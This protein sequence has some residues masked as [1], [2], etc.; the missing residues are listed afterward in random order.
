MAQLLSRIRS[1]VTIV[2][3]STV[4][5]LAGLAA[6]AVTHAQNT[7]TQQQNFQFHYQ[8]GDP[9]FVGFDWPWQS[10]NLFQV[11]QDSGVDVDALLQA[12]GHGIDWLLAN[13]G[14]TT[15]FLLERSQVSVEFL[16]NASGQTTDWLIGELG[17]D[18]DW[19]L[20]QAGHGS[21]WLL[22]R[23]GAA[24]DQ[25]LAWA[26]KDADWLL[27]QLDKDVDWLLDRTG[28]NVSWMLNRAGKGSSWVASQVKGIL[29][30][31]L[32]GMA[33][34][35]CNATVDAVKNSVSKLLGLLDRTGA[36]WLNRA[37]KSVDWLLGAAG[38]NTDWML[39]QAGRN[40][41]WLWEKLGKDADW[42]LA[43]TGKTKSW[44]LT[45][46]GHD[47]DWLLQRAGQGNSWLFQRLGKN[48]SWLLQQTNHD[49]DWVL[50][51]I[52]W[53]MSEA[54]LRFTLQL[55]L[56]VVTSTGLELSYPGAAQIQYVP[57]T[58]QTPEYERRIAVLTGQIKAAEGLGAT[59]A[60]VALTYTDPT[61]VSFSQT[62]DAGVFNQDMAITIDT[63]RR[64]FRDT[65]HADG[66]L[67]TLCIPLK[68]IISALLV[69]VPPAAATTL[70]LVPDVMMQ[71]NG[72]VGIRLRQEQ[73]TPAMGQIDT[74]R[75]SQ[76]QPAYEFQMNYSGNR[77]ADARLNGGSWGFAWG[78][79]CGPGVGISMGYD[80]PGGQTL[81][82]AGP[83]A[84]SDQQSVRFVLPPPSD[85]QRQ[86]RPPTRPLPGRTPLPI[87]PSPQPQPVQPVQPITPQPST[88]PVQ[89]TED[90]P[91]PMQLQPKQES[92]D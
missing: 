88:Q 56:Q 82:E 75:F 62:G 13:T 12:S 18:A 90:Q 73:V 76:P 6:P 67:L 91:P 11:L 3:V 45:L 15:E 87:Q 80:I 14:T 17:K 42:L 81:A 58:P 74:I 9:S 92:D 27:G 64:I 33:K 44:L 30:S 70:L 55:Q 57:G 86:P 40:R 38:R 83:G 89:P 84:M 25:L 61:G 23:S 10:P 20:D 2:A 7:Q 32:S 1:V 52:G 65:R 24:T 85:W 66:W 46:V 71:I 49:A 37:D 59:N 78:L 72:D 54:E 51:Q 5:V 50:E 43:H 48:A 39:S 19:I 63:S 8:I 21:D 26:D 47:A 31:H 16:L 41:T 60:G 79:M 77:Y 34:S 69:E 35:G 53:R 4:V 22:T 28:H 68:E 29:C 36:W